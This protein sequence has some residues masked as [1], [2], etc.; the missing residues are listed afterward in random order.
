[1]ENVRIAAP[2]PNLLRW[3]VFRDVGSAEF[4]DVVLWVPRVQ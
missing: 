3:L 2:S 1:L 4:V